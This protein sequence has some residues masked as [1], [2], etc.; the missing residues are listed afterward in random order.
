MNSDTW[1]PERLI[2]DR[3]VSSRFNILLNCKG[4]YVYAEL[5]TTTYGISLN[6]C[7]M[8]LKSHI[9]M[10][11]NKTDISHYHAKVSVLL[12]HPKQDKDQNKILDNLVPVFL[13]KS[14]FGS[15]W[16]ENSRLRFSDEP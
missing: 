5:N 1:F 15:R 16:S 7:N 4:T 2:S 11:K 6:I 14:L 8:L 13:Y 3:W 12:V 10:D 9:R